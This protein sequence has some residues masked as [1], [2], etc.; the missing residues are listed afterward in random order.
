ML[1]QLR[2][3]SRPMGVVAIA[4]LAYGCAA[5]TRPDTQSREDVLAR[6][7]PSA[8]QIVLENP[9]GRRF[10]TGSG[11]IIAARPSGAGS[12]SA[13]ECFV[14]TSGHTVT[15]TAGQK[16]IYLLFGRQQGEGTKAS[17]VVVA[18]RE[19]A[20]VDVALLRAESRDCVPARPAGAPKLGEPVWVLA[21]PWGRSM[22][23]AGGIVSQ[24]HADDVSRF[25]VDASVS[26]GS[27]GGGVYDA[28]SGGLIGLVEGYRTARVTSQGS[29][30]P[31]YIDVPMPGHTLVTPL[32]DIK[33]FLADTGHGDLIE[34]APSTSVRAV[35]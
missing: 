20:D 15:G 35:R 27:S 21:F 2:A 34:G 11:V 1:A 4:A 32:A 19:T 9:E 5:S 7:L 17:A 30:S 23:L 22:V 14:L 8:V 33:R 29:E 16:A 24:V 31:W 12:T 10:R 13:A 26:Y 3:R 28:G 18:H 25:M 6:L